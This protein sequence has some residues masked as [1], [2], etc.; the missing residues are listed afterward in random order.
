M[1]SR[2]PLVVLILSL[3]ETTEEEEEEPVSGAIMP[4]NENCILLLRRGA[5]SYTG[6]SFHL[7]LVFLDFTSQLFSRTPMLK[8]CSTGRSRS[9]SRLGKTPRRRRRWTRCSGRR[10]NCPS[11]RGRRRRKSAHK[12][13]NAKDKAEAMGRLFRWQC[14][15][16]KHD[17]ST[18]LMILASHIGTLRTS[19]YLYHTF[20]T[21]MTL[22]WSNTVLD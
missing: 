3:T 12:K 11:K 10:T 13:E 9:G 19:P 21:Y 8:R 4:G 6:R 2:D 1:F 18:H 5:L 20:I 17:D 22:C 14:F 16:T 7:R 15:A